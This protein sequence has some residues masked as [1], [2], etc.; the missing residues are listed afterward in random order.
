M[1]P[2][3]PCSF[4]D[5]E[6][7]VLRREGRILRRVEP[8]AAARLRAFLGSPL[9]QA[10]AAEGAII[11][12]WELP[13]GGDGAVWFEHRRVRFPSYPYEWSPAMLHAAAAH[14]IDLACRLHEAGDGLKDGTPYNIL[15]EKGR[16]VLVDVLSIEPRTPGDSVWRPLAQFA[17][18]FLLPLALNRTCGLPLASLLLNQREGIAPETA[19]KQLSWTARLRRPF[20]GLV[21]LPELLRR[22]GLVKESHYA[23]TPGGDPEKARFVLGYRF[24][25]LRRQVAALAPRA[26]AES[27]WTGY[28]GHLSYAEAE[29]QRKLNF[30]AASLAESRPRRVLDAGC[31]TGAFSLQAARAGASVVAI[32]SDEAVVD[33]LWRAAAAERLDI[34]PLAVNLAHPTPATGWRNSECDSFLQR[35]EGAFDM[36]LMLAVIHHLMVTER[37][38]IGEILALAA[39]LTRRDAVIE[40]VDPADPMFRT[41]V[42]GREHLHT[43]F[44]LIAFERAATAHFTVERRETINATRTIFHLRKR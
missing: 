38:P 12:T 21:T 39:L 2:V 41:I 8:A 43:D 22:L 13:E 14:T 20:L 6:G 4:R 33:H 17:S 10:L 32:D 1:T 40:Y 9:G 27:N 34:L 28:M 15:F 31:N 42:R 37:I 16:P 44:N 5:P 3:A 29:F 35:A 30:T 36:V 23:A 25:R 26:H 18:T 19:W 11:E 7:S 24:R